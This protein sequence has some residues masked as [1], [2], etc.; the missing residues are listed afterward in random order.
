MQKLKS[1]NG[2]DEC[3]ANAVESKPKIKNRTAPIEIDMYYQNEQ[4]E[5]P[6]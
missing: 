6:N 5:W 2:V 3:R 4:V 1:K